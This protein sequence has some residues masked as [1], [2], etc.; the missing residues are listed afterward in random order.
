MMDHAMMDHAMMV[1]D[2]RAFGSE[3]DIR[4]EKSGVIHIPKSNFPQ[5]IQKQERCYRM[6]RY[7]LCLIFVLLL[8]AGLMVSCGD[9]TK[10]PSDTTSSSIPVTDATT[11]TPET[12]Y[13]YTPANTDYQNT[14]FRIINLDNVANSGWSGTPSDLL[15]AENPH[16]DVLSEAVYTRNLRV[17][18]LLRVKIVVEELSSEKIT[19]LVN[20]TTM[21]G[22][23]EFDAV[24]CSIVQMSGFVSKQMLS[25]LRDTNINFSDPWWDQNS[26]EA[27]ELGGVLF[28][29]VSDMTFY[30][31]I[32]TYVTFFNT[33]F[34]SSNGLENPYDLMERGEWT[35]EKLLEMGEV[36]SKD[37]N[38]DSKY[39]ED[40]AYG[41]S[42][43]SDAAYVLLNAANK[44][45]IT[46]DE[47]GLP[48]YNLTDEHVILTLQRIY[49]LMLDSR[50]FFNRQKYGMN[51]QEAVN[52]F[53]ENRAMFMVR[54]I[55]SLFMMRQ[56]GADFGI[57]TLPKMNE[58]D[59]YVGSAVNPYS[60]TIL[61]L[62]TTVS[63]KARAADVLQAMACESH[64]TVQEPLFRVVLGAQLI[65]DERAV[66]MLDLAFS[67]R[68]Y[69]IGLVFDFNGIADKL[70]TNKEGDVV[71]KV[72]SWKRA[73]DKKI[74]ALIVQI[75]AVKAS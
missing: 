71:S 41:L 52:M 73:V 66:K 19:S 29:A 34:I 47:H 7:A 67:H 58:T 45:I 39:D 30:D 31:K 50:R 24:F 35:L 25:D 21:S 4:T 61:V 15:P 69:D 59:T 33:E 43:Q 17:E 51:I 53:T 65:R 12:E 20:K 40:D 56:M 10:K 62:P 42:F 2:S 64:Y 23:A 8:S 28:G 74:E 18:E 49:E 1:Y 36:A 37:V 26:I 70:M 13:R 63:D 46:K 6:K 72:T 11:E 5:N 54:P 14:E 9:N 55:Q 48:V 32:S 16:A 60:G 27:F 75:E 38:G 44:T 22:D 68:V 57:V 3:S